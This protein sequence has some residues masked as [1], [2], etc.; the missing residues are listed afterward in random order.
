MIQF[1][2]TITLTSAALVIALFFGAWLANTSPANSTTDQ[3][4]PSMSVDH[5]LANAEFDL[6]DGQAWPHFSDGC[7]AWIAATSERDGIDRSVSPVMHDA[8]HGFSIAGK[9][10]PIEVATR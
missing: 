6:C 8:E 1:A 4:T 7:T 2:K 10:Q 5:R 3:A 9:A